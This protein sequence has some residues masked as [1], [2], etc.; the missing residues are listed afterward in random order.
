MRSSLNVLLVYFVRFLYAFWDFVVEQ[1]IRLHVLL[2]LLL[3]LLLLISVLVLPEQLWVLVHRAGLLVELK[4][5]LLRVVEVLELLRQLM[6]LVQLC[7]TLVRVQ[8][9]AMQVILKSLPLFL[10][11]SHVIVILLVNL[12][13]RQMLLVRIALSI[14]I[15]QR[16]CLRFWYAARTSILILLHKQ[17]ILCCTQRHVL[18]LHQVSITD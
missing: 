10:V 6:Q 4:E 14:V 2:T 11:L 3:L 15:R 18:M 16:Y 13:R 1:L 12:L 17:G 7:L 8:V 9:L 5:L